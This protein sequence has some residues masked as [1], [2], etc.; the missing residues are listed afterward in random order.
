M[1]EQQCNTPST[2]LF[3]RELRH[4]MIRILLFIITLTAL[5]GA[6][7]FVIDDPGYSYTKIVNSKPLQEVDIR[8][9]ISLF[10][11]DIANDR[12]WPD[13]KKGALTKVEIGK[14]TTLIRLQFVGN[15]AAY[16]KEIANHY[17]E[18]TVKRINE[19]AKKKYEINFNNNYLNIVRK[20]FNWIKAD[21]ESRSITYKSLL[22]A[23]RQWKDK[24]ETELKHNAMITAEVVVVPADGPTRL[25]RKK[26]LI[27]LSVLMGIFLSIGYIACKCAWKRVNDN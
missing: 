8:N 25:P 4:N 13:R 1:N 21:L 11:D 15:D 22:P 18:D 20:Q 27:G 23:L 24:Y 17:A 5:T 6:Y 16:L 9:F 12:L 19:E 7:V 10:K 26:S 3:I 14:G 2:I